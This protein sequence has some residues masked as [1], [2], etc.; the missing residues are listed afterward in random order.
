M[1]LDMLQNPARKKEARLA[2]LSGEYTIA[3]PY[4][5]VQ[6]GTGALLFDPAYI[7]D[8]NG[9]EKFWGFSILV[10]NW[11]NFIQEVELE[12]LE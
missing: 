7:T 5:L 4:E 3:G 12:K 8:Q 10:M 2:R 11:D 6:G 9:E 1:G